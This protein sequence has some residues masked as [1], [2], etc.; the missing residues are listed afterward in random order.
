MR[1][2][3]QASVLVL[4][5]MLAGAASA[6]EK[7]AAAADSD[8]GI[9]DIIITATRQATNLQKTPIAI[10]AVTGE[11]LKDAGLKSVADLSAVVP[12]AQFRRVQGAFGPGVTTFIR[13]LGT[14]DTSLGG[15]AAVAY[16]IDDVYYPILL[17]SNFDLLD[18]DHIE[19][20]R[21]PQGTLFGRNSLAGAVNIVSKQPSLAGASGYLE[22]TVGQLD[23]REFRGGFNMPISDTMA[24]MVSGLSKKRRGYQRVLDFTC[25]MN[26]RGTPALAGS[27]PYIDQMRATTPNY[28][29]TDCTVGTL[30]GEDVQGLK[31]SFLWQVTPD[32]KLTLSYDQTWDNSENPAD[33]T[34]DINPAA[35][36]ANLKA[37]ADYFG[38]VYDSRF[39]T[40]D[41]YTTYASY[42]DRIA[43][44][45][46]LPVTPAS[47]QFYTGA[48]T[49]GGLIM[50][51]YGQL[52]NW[53]YSG[54]L[55]WSA[56]D[57]IDV[58]AIFGHREMNEHHSF[59]NDGGP[60]VIEHVLSEIGEK[61]DNAE[62]RISGK[63]DLIDWVVGGFYFDGHGY[64]HA[65]NYSPTA[66]FLVKTL[67]T[68]F[69]PNSKAV[70]ANATVR[71]FGEQFGIVLGARYSWDHKFVDYANISDV[72]VPPHPNGGDTIFQVDPT[73]RKFSWKLGL[74]YQLNNNVLLYASAATG[75]SLPGY[76]ARPLQKTQVFQI[77]GNDN[78]AYEVGAKLDLL[79]R[80]L[81][82]NLSAFYTDFNNRPTPVAGGSEPTLD[83][84]G[85][86]VAGN[87]QLEP[88]PG[89]PPGSTRCSATLLPSN[90]GIV[91]FGRPYY[92]S[93]PAKI[94]GFE[95]EYTLNPVEGLLINGSLGWSK[96]T[97]PSIDAQTVHKRQLNPSWTAGTSVQYTI[98]MPGMGGSITPRIDWQFQSREYV[99]GNSAKYDSFT[100]PRGL[101][102]TR[103]TYNNTDHDFSVAVGVTN[104]F[105]KFYYLNWFDYQTF[106]RANTEA[107]PGIPRQ[108]YLTVGKKF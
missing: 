49:R 10:T 89:G 42:T 26:R 14:G 93:Q 95:V 48:N 105:N 22:A 16:Y 44:G 20:L 100:G 86:P 79:D 62:L 1:A 43:R 15:E 11:T 36:P 23:R 101:V 66:T 30:G 104:L 88:L 56:T 83:S 51:P 67:N 97:A 55:V 29:A 9:G 76:N 60:L 32:I 92:T 52:S 25:E 19:V 64:F 39:A 28:K 3:S 59:D 108:W 40:G 34:V 77:D 12:N 71:P 74:N 7:P 87:Q 69:D 81:R 63:S 73:Q 47:Q 61:Y 33:S 75:N 41:P 84:A 5:I 18:I 17:G 58:T 85:N 91:C 70:Y 21:G 4:G 50:S 6:Q 45:T 106:G 72:N 31:A 53:G 37:Q 35:V 2:F 8:E 94:R 99:S 82:L 102:N 107:Q 103:I 38:L 96:F 90:T 46:V 98:K 13:G 68:T 54:K 78:R 65:V 24:V 80:K 57:D 27:F